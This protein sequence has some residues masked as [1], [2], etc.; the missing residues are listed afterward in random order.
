MD[1]I[2]KYKPPT[3]SKL[4]IFKRI[5]DFVK[6][7]HMENEITNEFLI[8]YINL[9]NHHE[10]DRVLPELMTGKY[11]SSDCLSACENARNHLAVAYIKA[12]LGFY[13]EALEIYKK[14]LKKVLKALSRGK[15]WDQP[16][17]K[18]KLLSRLHRESDMALELC[19]EAEYPEKVK[20][21]YNF[22]NRFYS[23]I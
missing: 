1:F 20:K 22:F 14:R 10:K 6:K 11:P 5:L 4:E 21:A 9:L 23:S 16:K 2:L 3:K 18:K 13:D 8:E 19:R 15:R 7:Q 12:R 17:K